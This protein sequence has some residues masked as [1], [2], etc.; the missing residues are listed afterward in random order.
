MQ[1]LVKIQYSQ[2]GDE[3]SVP[4]VNARDLWERLEVKTQF[5]DWIR[6]RLEE[7][8]LVKG[9]DF[10]SMLKNE[11]REIGATTKKEYALSMVGIW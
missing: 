3:I 9:Q 11:R 4:A 8:Q 10:T 5:K 1:E 7:A 2:I 6:R